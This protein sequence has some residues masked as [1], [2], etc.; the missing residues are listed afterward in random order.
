VTISAGVA[1]EPRVGD[2]DAA[3]AFKARADEALYAAKRGGRDRAVVW[4][5]DGVRRVDT[6][7]VGVSVVGAP[8]LDGP[9]HALR[10]RLSRG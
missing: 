4:T 5:P 10:A 9:L 7:P 8:H 1:A 6:P 2:A 3:E